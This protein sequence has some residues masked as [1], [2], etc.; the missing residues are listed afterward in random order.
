M[1]SFADEYML[2]KIF[3]EDDELKQTYSDAIEKH[4]A[5]INSSAFPD[6]GFDLFTP[7]QHSAF[8][9]LTLK[10]DFGIVAAG[11]SSSLGVPLSF[12]TYPRSSIYKTPLRLANS[13]GI[14]DSGYR[15]HLMGM[16]DV[17]QTDN[18]GYLLEKN[19]RLVQICAPN[20]MPIRVVLVDSI[21]DLGTTERGDGGFGSTGK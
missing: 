18:S 1:T 8:S 2:L 17:Q 16:F 3:V 11:F 13:V 21:D 10:V 14:I 5:K 9:F 15:G 19:T 12:Y 6:A 20:L 4:N 7:K